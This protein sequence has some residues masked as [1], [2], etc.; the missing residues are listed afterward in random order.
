MTGAGRA[1]AR[2]PALQAAR[3]ADAGRSGRAGVRSRRGARQADTRCRRAARARGR[4]ARQARRARPA[5]RPGRGLGVQLGQWA[6]HSVHS[7]CFWPG[8][9]RY[10]S[11]VT[12]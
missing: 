8:S 2:G 7:A 4:E 9:T 3:H 5:G 1:W 10:F 12:K 11:R 6:V